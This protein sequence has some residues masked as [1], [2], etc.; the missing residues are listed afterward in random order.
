M[1]VA[2]CRLHS[3]ITVCVSNVD[4]PH[5]SVIVTDILQDVGVAAVGGV[6]VTVGDVLLG[7]KVPPQLA[8]Q[9]VV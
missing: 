4:L 7:E 3:I 2:T 6:Y 8:D 5:S 9:T 1:V